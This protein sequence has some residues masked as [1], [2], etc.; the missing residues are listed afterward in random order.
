MPVAGNASHLFALDV[1]YPP[2]VAR[3]RQYG[4]ELAANH[5]FDELSHPRAQAGLDR[6]EP[7]VE[8]MGGTIDS[9][10]RRLRHRGNARHGV[11]SRP[12]LQRRVIRG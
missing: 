10:L 9:W 1:P 3:T 2:A 4:V 11:V 8:K 7:I 6:I 12:A 5:L